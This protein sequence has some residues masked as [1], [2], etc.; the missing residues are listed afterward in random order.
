H[1][2]WPEREY[3]IIKKSKEVR[4]V[5]LPNDEMFLACIKGH[6]HQ[7]NDF[8]KT[9]ADVEKRNP[10]NI[11]V[12]DGLVNK[13]IFGCHWKAMS[14]FL[15][16][17]RY[18]LVAQ[19]KGELSDNQGEAKELSGDGLNL[20]QRLYTMEHNQAYDFE[21]INNFMKFLV[22][23]IGKL[24]TPIKGSKFDL[25]W[26]PS[27]D[28]QI[29]VAAS[30]TGIEQLLMLATVL[31]TEHK[32]GIVLLEEPENHLHPGAQEKLMQKLEPEGGIG[33]KHIFITTHSPVLVQTRKETT[34]VSLKAIHGKGTHG[35]SIAGDD[36]RTVLE[37]I[38]VRASHFA[39]SDIL[40][41]VEGITSVRVVEEW[42]KKWTELDGYREDVQ[43][44]VHQFNISEVNNESFDLDRV[45]RLNN[46]VVF[47]FDRDENRETGQSSS[48]HE[49]LEKLC[50]NHDPP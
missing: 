50:L 47:F 8:L 2:V 19:R 37:D 25:I 23:G 7:E 20:A 4:L 17:P 12:P 41:L 31:F 49:K 22:P 38:G 32:D 18:H 36:V 39:L 6:F 10:T 21:S 46:N 5:E 9:F 1:L 40:V 3:T 24:V 15:D 30:G 43:I 44:L 11:K 33:G 29:P 27:R 14:E 35:T 26:E 48:Y 45:L 42:I 28:V 34:I 16:L 13:P